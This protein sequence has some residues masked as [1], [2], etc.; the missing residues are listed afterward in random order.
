[1]ST[2]ARYGCWRSPI[3]AELV[4]RGALRLSQPAIHGSTAYWVETR[5]ADSAHSVLVRCRAGE[6]PEDVTCAPFSVRSRAREYGGGA[7]AAVDDCGFFVNGDDQQVYRFGQPPEQ[8]TRDSAA[9]WADLRPDPARRR[10]I[11]V[12]ERHRTGREPEDCLAAID[13]V[14][15]VVHVLASGNDF[16][17]SPRF[18]PDGR[19]LAWISWN[20]PHLP[21]TQT[22]LWIAGLTPEGALE[23]PRALAKGCSIQQPAFSADGSLYFMADQ[24]GWWNLWRWD[25]ESTRQ[26]VCEQAEYGLPTWQYGMSTYGFIDERSALCACVRDGTWRVVRVNLETGSR[27]PVELPFTDIAH[28]AVDG[29]FAILLAGAPDHAQAIVRLD[30]TSGR[31]EELRVSGP[32]LPGPLSMPIPLEYA[33]AEGETAHGFWYPPTGAAVTPPR[34]ERPPLRVKCHGGPTGAASLSL[35]P[36]IQYWTSRGWAVLDVDYRGS[37]GYGR[38][39]R[40]Q[41]YG[42]W[43]EADV[44]DCAHGVSHL[45]AQ[46]VADGT[47]AVVA[48]SSAGGYTALCALAFTSAFRGGASYYGIADPATLF[49]HTHKFEAHYDRW[50]LGPDREQWRVARSPLARAGCIRCPV[51]LVQGLDDKIVPPEQTERLAAALRAAGTDVAY[52]CFADEG[53]GFRGATTIRRALE[54]EYD[55]LCRAVGL[56]TI[57]ER[58]P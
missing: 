36:R 2:S 29:R 1:M 40:E 48:G 43:G 10:L 33:S 20:H 25:G 24:S 46:Q 3:S 17:A 16:Y 32:E 23:A 15:G 58:N 37:T 56:P 31:Y 47:R 5:P 39:Y 42:R 49:A 51:L 4:A 52:V 53:H 35:D 19:R 45:A 55:F 13:T 50:L 21:W 57:G 6:S 54:A 11:A 38:A 27:D 8:M 12:R 30:T 28:L 22:T 41:L 14:D 44:A 18:A 26:I 7:F 34:A 9:R